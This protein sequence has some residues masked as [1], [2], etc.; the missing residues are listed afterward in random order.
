[1]DIWHTETCNL[2]CNNQTKPLTVGQAQKWINMSLKYML[3][4]GDKEIKG[5]SKNIQYYHIPIDNLIQKEFE[6][7]Y[8]IKPI[9]GPWSAI[10]SYP[11]YLNY[12][13]EVRKLTANIP[14]A[15]E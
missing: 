13:D 11:T 5:I 3:C 12:Q 8:S 1:F 6:N 15:L 7:V 2:L 4:F 14:I 9:P 10:K